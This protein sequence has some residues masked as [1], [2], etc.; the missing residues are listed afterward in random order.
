MASL[1]RRCSRRFPDALSPSYRSRAI[2]C[3]Y[4]SLYGCT[5]FEQ[6]HRV[7]FPPDD[8]AF[9][10]PRNQ[11][12]TDSF[13]F[14]FHLSRNF[15]F[16]IPKEYDRSTYIY[17]HGPLT[18]LELDLR[19]VSNYYQCSRVEYRNTKR[20]NSSFFST[21]AIFKLVPLDTRI[22]EIKNKTSNLRNHFAGTFN[23]EEGKIHT[24]VLYRGRNMEDGVHALSVCDKWT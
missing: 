12:S 14:R 15:Q 4:L 1:P 5:S 8:T 17:I 2:T 9:R 7:S 23:G 6:R 21:S 11:F 13:E 18:L 16:S 24:S 20:R 10:G 3:I 22:Q 19:R